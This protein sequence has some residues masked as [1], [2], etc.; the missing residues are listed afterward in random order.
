[1]SSP[2][3]PGFTITEDVHATTEFPTQQH[4]G[5]LGA[6][7]QLREQRAA[8]LER[9]WLQLVV[10][11]VDR[12]D[13]DPARVVEICDQLGRTE[14]DL[15]RDCDVYRERAELRRQAARLVDEQRRHGELL[16]AV[17]TAGDA[18]EAAKASVTRAQ[19][20][21]GDAG[22]Q[23]NNHNRVMDQL[24]KARYRLNEPQF[25]R[26]DTDG[27]SELRSERDR[28]KAQR[29]ALHEKVASL[30]SQ[31]NDLEHAVPYSRQQWE[32]E[33][34]DLAKTNHKVNVDRQERSLV[35]AKA[36]LKQLEGPLA[37]MEIK[38]AALESKLLESAAT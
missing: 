33:T 8:E 34:N 23:L 25:T 10:D 37:E 15:Q 35:D 24:R 12:G 27:E 38:L 17:K 18:L 7:Q 22:G 20:A 32:Q 5:T 19:A 28:I 29:D 16:E 9:N 36:K 6:A 3:E 26:F 11:L 1:M 14:N 13:V 30:R 2:H 31:V 4:T 21:C